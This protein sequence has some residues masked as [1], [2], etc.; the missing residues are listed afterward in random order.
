M[1]VF[2]EVYLCALSNLLSLNQ[3]FSKSTKGHQTSSYH[4]IILKK[5]MGCPGLWIL[6]DQTEKQIL[7]IMWTFFFIPKHLCFLYYMNYWNKYLITPMWWIISTTEIK[8]LLLKV[9][10]EVCF[11]FLY[12]F[13]F[14]CFILSPM[15]FWY[16]YIPSIEIKEAK[17][18]ITC[19]SIEG[20]SLQWVRVPPTLS[21]LGKF[22]LLWVLF[23]FLK[24]QT[25][26]L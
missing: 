5:Q 17:C 3:S 13:I 19:H 4:D 18:S 12:C 26:H 15:I 23:H 10:F 11:H 20:T 6:I 21:M 24:K 1:W 7:K 8:V 22:W 25:G 2:N 9:K 14:S 16:C